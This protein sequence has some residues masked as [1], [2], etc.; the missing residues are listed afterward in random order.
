[1]PS[2]FTWPESTSMR[3]KH[4]QIKK[5]WAFFLETDTT[6]NKPSIPEVH[7]LSNWPQRCNFASRQALSG[8]SELPIIL[9]SGQI[10]AI[11]RQKTY[12]KFET[13][14]SDY[15]LH[16]QSESMSKYLKAIWSFQPISLRHCDSCTCY[17]GY[18]DLPPTEDSLWHPQPAFLSSLEALKSQRIKILGKNLRVASDSS[19]GM[20]LTYRCHI[21]SQLNPTGTKMWWIVRA[22]FTSP[23]SSFPAHPPYWGLL[24]I[25]AICAWILVLGSAYAHINSMII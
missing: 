13:T 3:E 15:E 19:S 12:M 5:K 11:E 16:H 8:S 22:M 23:L 7:P 25:K 24:L 20:I 6:K 1:M 2:W 4:S 18:P 21:Y 10:M 9:R 17:P 14:G